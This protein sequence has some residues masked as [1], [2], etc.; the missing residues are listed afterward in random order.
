V[1]GL[2]KWAPSLGSEEF[3]FNRLFDLD[4]P[5]PMP[6][7][8]LPKAAEFARYAIENQGD[9]AVAEGGQGGLPMEWLVQAGQT[10]RDSIQ[11]DADVVLFVN[12][13]LQDA[14]DITTV[15]ALPT[16]QWVM[17]FPT[18]PPSGTARS[19]AEGIERAKVAYTG[20][21][22]DAD[23]Y[24]ELDMLRDISDEMAKVAMR[25]FDMSWKDLETTRRSIAYLEKLMAGAKGQE[26]HFRT[27]M[28]N[29]RKLLAEAEEAF[30]LRAETTM[31]PEARIAHLFG[32]AKKLE[33][34]LETSEQRFTKLLAE[35]NRMQQY[36][37][38]VLHEG[39]E[40]FG[41][42]RQAPS[43]V[44]GIMADIAK[45]HNS[46][47]G[48]GLGGFLRGFDRVNSWMKGW[49]TS[50]I[51]FQTRNIFG[52]MFNNWL[53]GVDLSTAPMEWG[54]IYWATRPQ[55]MKNPAKAAKVSWS[56]RFVERVMNRAGVT[57]SGLFHSELG[58]LESM[59]LVN[60]AAGIRTSGKSFV[61]PYAT[62]KLGEQVTEPWLRGTLAYDRLVKAISQGRFKQ[63]GLNS[64][65]DVTEANFDT[66]W[67]EVSDSVVMSEII[68]D[69]AKYHFNYEDLSAFE[70][71]VGRRAIPFYTWTRKNVPLQVEALF[72]Q[73]GKAYNRYQ[74]VKRNMEYGTEDEQIV[75]SYF[76]EQQMIHLP[77]TIGGNDLYGTVELPFKDP[78]KVADV[79]GQ[80]QGMLNPLVKAPIEYMAGRQLFSDV[81]LTDDYEEL[82][83]TWTPILPLLRIGAE[84]PFVPWDPPKQAED[85]TWMF[86]NKDA[87]LVAQYLPFLAQ[88]RR[89][90]PSEEKYEKRLWS[91]AISYMMGVNLRTNT[92]Q[93]MESEVFRRADALGSIVNDLEALGKLP[94]EP[95]RLKRQPTMDLNTML[96]TIQPRA[97]TFPTEEIFPAEEG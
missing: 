46:M 57:G 7:D 37:G 90:L 22:V 82:P 65:A 68:D 52:G 39:W 36:L 4:S 13:E 83:I 71:Q 44:V 43:E 85:G 73:P 95:Q 87:H 41:F 69:V 21:L 81:P 12:R 38:N 93:D 28:D 34:A 49:L 31:E 14:Y 35:R 84:L 9:R 62:R 2:A 8:Y 76:A 61:L 67:R 33:A 56:D 32:Q 88:T 10:M 91:T 70:R 5:L 72:T 1:A 25:T 86:R 58:G 6:G 89:L 97:D 80:L 11:R 77:W 59:S 63:L 40:G 30:K 51:G 20:K 53:A 27:I 24:I 26:S 42:G 64:L 18:P 75:P 66:L 54:R 23:K 92:P 29:Q 45:T 47:T 15:Q 17:E 60:P 94:Q 74:A 16:A 55:V 3:D 48:E 96:A 78:F 50:S 79:T 19:V